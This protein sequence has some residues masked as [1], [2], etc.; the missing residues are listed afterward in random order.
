MLMTS[1]EEEF[2]ECQFLRTPSEKKDKA[3]E[4][5]GKPIDAASKHSFRKSECDVSDSILDLASLLYTT[6]CPING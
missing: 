3:P 6:P 2:T 5:D 4:V 1:S